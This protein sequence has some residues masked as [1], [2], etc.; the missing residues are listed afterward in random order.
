MFDDKF[1]VVN[2]TVMPVGKLQ[3][4][5][6]ILNY[7]HTMKSQAKGIIKFLRMNGNE[8]P[9]DIVTKSHASNTWFPLMK[10]LIFWRD[11]DFLK[12]PVVSEESENRSS[13]PPLSQSKGTPHQSFNI[14]FRNILGD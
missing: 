2:S 5:S 6:H 3:L 13:T 10:P 7:H 8:N 4:C 11:M 14:Y 12:D 9:A 1:S